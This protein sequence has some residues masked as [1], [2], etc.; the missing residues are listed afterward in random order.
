MYVWDHITSY[1][2][3]STSKC[4]YLE[5][6]DVNFTIWYNRKNN[7]YLSLSVA[8]LEHSQ[9]SRMELFAKIVN[10]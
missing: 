2:L 3:I 4:Q 5:S 7:T 1:G 10:C 9:T 6:C 8:Y